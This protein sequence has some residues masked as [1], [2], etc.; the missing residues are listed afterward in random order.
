MDWHKILCIGI[1]ED[2][3]M[4]PMQ[5]ILVILAMYCTDFFFGTTVTLT[6]GF[7]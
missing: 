2:L 1:H 6:C 7:K 5:W 3:F 4:D